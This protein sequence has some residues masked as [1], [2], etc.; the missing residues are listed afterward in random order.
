MHSTDFEFADKR[1]SDFGW[2]TCVIG[3][4]SGTEEV[5]IG[6][7]ITFNTVKNNQSSIHSSTSSSYDSVYTTPFQIVKKDCN[8]ENKYPTH[9][10]IRVLYKWLNR[11]KYTKFKPVPNNDEYC[12]VYYFGSFNIQEVFVAGRIIGLT[13]NFTGN[14]P[15]GFG[16]DNQFQITISEEN[17][18]FSIY[19]D[20]DEVDSI[21]Y[22]K[23]EVTCLQDGDLKITNLTT[24]NYIFIGNCLAGEVITLDGEYGIQIT[25]MENKHTTFSSDFN[26]SYLDIEIGENEGY[27]NEYEVSMPCEIII[28]YSPIRKVGV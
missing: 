1:L 3:G 14:A 19:G 27:E 4:N 5:N 2:T 24:E 6:C 25:S 21:I 15:Y 11:R 8:G 23:V 10:E 7:D 22:P 13:L 28:T 18:T 17:E 16:E 12:D 9:D 20:S 26:Y